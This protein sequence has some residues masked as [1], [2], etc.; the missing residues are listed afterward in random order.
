MI[1]Y[2]LSKNEEELEQILDLQQRNLP[3]NLPDLEKKEQGFVT[4][5]HSLIDLKKLSDIHRQV[6][7]FT[8]GAS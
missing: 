8:Y 2:Q 3:R 1:R 4:V 5:E 7:G 6:I